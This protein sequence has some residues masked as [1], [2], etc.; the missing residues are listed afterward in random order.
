M[1]GIAVDAP[2]RIASAVFLE[3]N[4]SPKNG[5]DKK[6][7]NNFKLKTNVLSYFDLI[8]NKILMI[9]LSMLIKH[10]K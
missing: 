2:W 10:K 4:I 8:Q 3:G 7:L 5:V 9:T 1:A 6:Y